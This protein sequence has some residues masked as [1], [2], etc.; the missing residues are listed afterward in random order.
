[1]EDPSDILYHF[2]F[3]VHLPGHNEY[4]NFLWSCFD[5]NYQ[6]GKYSF[7]FIA[8]HMMYMT[9]VYYTLWKIKLCRP[10]EFRLSLIGVYNQH[11]K[12]IQN[13]SDP[14]VFSCLRERSIFEFMELLDLDRSAIGLLKKS[15]EL[16]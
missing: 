1:M 9:C 2:P 11:K 13:G 8:Y 15:V 12:D 16:S 4:I 10:D 6:N 3:D 7:A 14:F 5:S